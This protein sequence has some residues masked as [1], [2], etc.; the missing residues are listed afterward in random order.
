MTTTPHNLV[1]RILHWA[2]AILIFW[3]IGLGL[4]A[5][6]MPNSPDKIELFVLHKSA[7]F[8]VLVLAVIRLFWRLMHPPAPLGL[9]PLQEKMAAAGHWGLYLLMLAVPFSGWLLNSTAGYP[10]AWFNLVSIPHIPGLEGESRD[11]YSSLHVYLFYGIAFMVVG[12]VAMLVVHK[13][14]DGVNLLPRMLPGKV[15]VGA[16]ALTITLALLLGFTFYK[17][18]KATPESTDSPQAVAQLPADPEAKADAS[19]ST[20]ETDSPLWQLVATPDNFKFT[21]SY[22]G[23]PFVGAIREFTPKIYFDPANPADGVIDVTINTQSITTNNK[24]WDGTI[25]GGQWFSTDAFPQAHYISR[26]I[27]AEDGKF[28][29][30]GELTLKGITKPIAVTFEWQEDNSTAK[31]VGSATIDRREFEIGSGSWATND[32]VA[33]EVVLDIDLQLRKQN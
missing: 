31:F 4:I 9:P 16:S 13:L 11:L 2:I 20:I 15:F 18:D 5:E 33:Y 17:A 23:Q 3:A 8:T 19:Q 14:F 7:G 28:V 1:A 32:S 6:D 10:F 30:N 27:R 21:N 24:D 25:K 22:A 12:H 29:A 26:D